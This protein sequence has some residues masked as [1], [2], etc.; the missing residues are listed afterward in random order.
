VSKSRKQITRAVC[1]AVLASSVLTSPDVRAEPGQQERVWQVMEEQS[2]EMAS[3][4]TLRISVDDADLA[5][6]GDGETNATVEIRLRSNDMQRATDLYERSHYRARLEGNDIIVESDGRPND[7]WRQGFW[8]SVIVEVRVPERFNLDLTTEDGDVSLGS[9]DGRIRVRTEDGDVTADTLSGASIELHSDDGD[10]VARELRGDLIDTQTEDGDITIESLTG[11]VTMKTR[12]GDIR[13][14]SA[15][16]E[17]LTLDSGD[18]DIHIAIT[19][20]ARMDVNTEDGD[21]SIVAPSSLRARLDLAGED[22]SIHG[23]FR[24]SGSIHD[25]RAEGELN[26]GGERIR[27]HTDEGTVRLLE[28]DRR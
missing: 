8:M 26:G 7:E 9:H 18:G 2:F 23:A 13:V 28:A 19:G 11:P 1:L 10:I 24:I 22:V 20:A 12:D 14:G 4:G 16:A 6:V 17:A 15:A 5:V 27:A 25:G 21:I 3:I